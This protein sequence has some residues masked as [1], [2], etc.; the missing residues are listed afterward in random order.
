MK[1]GI[2]VSKK[3]DVRKK[4]G[5]DRSGID[6]GIIGIAHSLFIVGSIISI[7]RLFEIALSVMVIVDMIGQIRDTKMMI[8]VSMDRLGEECQFMIG[9]G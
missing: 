3:I 2:A 4:K 6:I 5:A 7:C 9:W 8:D 1:I